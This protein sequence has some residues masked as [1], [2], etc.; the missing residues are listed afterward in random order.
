MSFFLPFSLRF[1]SLI[2][3][4]WI[5]H[6]Y[7]SF[8]FEFVEFSPMKWSNFLF[9]MSFFCFFLLFSLR[10]SLSCAF[11]LMISIRIECEFSLLKAFCNFY[12]FSRRFFF[13]FQ[14]D[15][16]LFDWIVHLFLRD[17]FGEFSCWSFVLKFSFV[18][19]CPF[20]VRFSS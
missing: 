19:F 16:N 11:T 18:F 8:K 4:R 15:L 3:F 9:E 2:E 13:D 12:K 5:V 6:L 14:F 1:E 10:S 17:I 20:S 7:L